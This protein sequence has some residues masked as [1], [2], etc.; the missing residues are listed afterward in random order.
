MET[1]HLVDKRREQLERLAKISQSSVFS[2]V[3][4]SPSFTS[5]FAQIVQVPGV[6]GLDNN[7]IILEF[8]ANLGMDDLSVL[9]ME[10]GVRM[11]LSL[12]H[13]VLVLRSGN[14][15][16]G[17]QS[18]IHIWISETHWENAN[19]LILLAFI[20]MGHP[21]WKR[22]EIEVFT[23]IDA[24]S[25]EKRKTELAQ[26]IHHGRI[27]ISMKNI[28]ILESS[29]SVDLEKLISRYSM[30]ADLVFT[31]FSA[32]DFEEHG[33]KPFFICPEIKN[34]LFVRARCGEVALIESA[35]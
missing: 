27:P 31:G 6:V 26:L 18:S 20:I 24:A 19:L 10:K 29:E 11:A 15:N 23:A 12:N 35:E 4:L 16:F 32:F 22:S 28:H 1:S 13:N 17:Y 14:Y 21:E 3:I 2:A 33:S 9:D 34:I 8:D 30:N 7:G 25:M 5:A